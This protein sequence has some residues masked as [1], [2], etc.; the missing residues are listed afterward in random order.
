MPTVQQREWLSM[1]AMGSDGTK[2][3]A[4]GSTMVAGVHLRW[5]IAGNLGFPPDAF[6]VYRCDATKIE[7]FCIDIDGD[8]NFSTPQ[9][10]VKIGDPP[11]WKLSAT[12]G[13]VYQSGVC[14]EGAGGIFLEGEQTLD[15]LPVIPAIAPFA[16]RAVKVI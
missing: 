15:V 13:M 4:D 1:L 16:V 11:A 3:L 9:Q 2:S 6:D 14:S 5:S 8:L 12:V 10:T 7:W